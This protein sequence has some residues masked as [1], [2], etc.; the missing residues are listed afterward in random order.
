MCE[1]CV[2]DDLEEYER[3]QTLNT[4]TVLLRLRFKSRRRHPQRLTRAR[5]DHN[6]DVGSCCTKSHQIRSKRRTKRQ[7]RQSGLAVFLFSRSSPLFVWELSR[8]YPGLH[9]PR[10]DHVGFVDKHFVFTLTILCPMERETS[11]QLRRLLNYRS[12]T[13]PRVCPKECYLF[14]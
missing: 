9:F 14:V 13:H 8:F 1:I 5:R 12:R 3:T 11:L 2:I 7:H 4:R 10:V 6:K